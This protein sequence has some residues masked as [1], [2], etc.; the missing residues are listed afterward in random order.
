MWWL[1]G[2][3]FGELPLPA[4]DEAVVVR[5][6]EKM[7]SL[8]EAACQ[9]PIGPGRSCSPEPLDEAIQRGTAFQ[10]QVVPDARITYLIGLARLSKGERDLARTAFREAVRMDPHRVDAWHDLGEVALED[11]D[12]A[13]AREAFGQV[14]TQVD[15]GSQAW[16]GPWRL[17]EVAAHEHDPEA[18]EGHM[19]VALERGFSFRF[20]QGLPTWRGF[21]ADP[22]VGPSVRKL[23]T[24]YGSP[25]ILESLE[26]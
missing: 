16:L 17:A 25:E 26:R 7:N 20:V 13:T 22:A 18:F 4:Y 19:R 2:V 11:G 8:V 21:L 15:K 10:E 3:A 12:Y 9:G 24:V 1:A 23:V 6:W 14:A 5:T